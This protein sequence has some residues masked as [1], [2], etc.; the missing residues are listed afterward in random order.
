MS[1]LEIRLLGQVEI[2]FSSDWW[3][4]SRELAMFDHDV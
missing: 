3:G 1:T 2:W 4:R